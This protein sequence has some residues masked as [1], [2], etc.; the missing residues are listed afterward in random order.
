MFKVSKLLQAGKHVCGSGRVL[1]SCP[2]ITP[3]DNS[4]TEPI[5][6]KYRFLTCTCTI[7]LYQPILTNIQKKVVFVNQATNEE[8]S[9]SF[10]PG[11]FDFPMILIKTCSSC[12]RSKLFSTF[13]HVPPVATTHCKINTSV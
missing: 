3:P 11:L 10:S 4:K 6:V 13:C 7:F 5:S 12:N 9:V 8:L 2:S 1:L